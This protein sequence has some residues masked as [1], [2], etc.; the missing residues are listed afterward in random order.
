M[1]IKEIYTIF[2]VLF[3]IA[4]IAK[5]IIFFLI[6]DVSISS[7]FWHSR[8]ELKHT[9][10]KKDVSLK[11]FSNKISYLVLFFGV[12]LIASYSFY[13]MVSEHG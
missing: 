8:V 4:T 10:N 5:L 13:Q 1:I 12:A 6:K 3:L 7:I 2:M 9:P 11:K